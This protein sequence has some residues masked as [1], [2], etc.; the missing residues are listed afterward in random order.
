MVYTANWG[1][2]CDLPP[3]RGTRNNHWFIQSQENESVD[4]LISPRKIFLTEFFYRNW[5]LTCHSPYSPWM[6]VVCECRWLH[7]PSQIHPHTSGILEVAF[8]IYTLEINM[9]PKVMEVWFRSDDFPYFIWVIFRFQPLVFRGC[10]KHQHRHQWNLVINPWKHHFRGV[11]GSISV[12]FIT[13]VG[14]KYPT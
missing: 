1:I 5:H 10:T 4:S 2:I 3:V 7:L 6:E 9:E 13:L 14:R 8:W 12:S 11:N